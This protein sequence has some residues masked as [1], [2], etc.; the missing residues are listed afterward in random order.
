[1]I[2]DFLREIDEAIMALKLAGADVP[3]YIILKDGAV[4]FDFGTE[5]KD[6]GL[7]GEESRG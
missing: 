2:D 7:P 5:E 3:H 1:M 4:Y 6:L